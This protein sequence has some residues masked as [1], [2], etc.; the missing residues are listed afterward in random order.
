MSVAH[1]D[2]TTV[3]LLDATGDLLALAEVANGHL[4]LKKV[5]TKEE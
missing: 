3:A 5:F 2:G 4:K 1:P